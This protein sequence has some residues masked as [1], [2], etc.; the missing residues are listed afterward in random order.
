M[1][2]PAFNEWCQN[3]AMPRQS[4]LPPSLSAQLSALIT[5]RFR[6]LSDSELQDILAEFSEL[7]AK[8]IVDASREMTDVV[9]PYEPSLLEQLR[10][11][12]QQLMKRS[13]DY[14]W[15]FLFHRSGYVREAAL[16]VINAPPASAF[17]LSALAW[18]LNDWVG[19]VRQAAVRCAERVFPRISP[20]VAASAAPYLLDRR[21]VWAR[22]R[23]EAK[24]L[25]SVFGHTD[26]M[27]ALAMRMQKQQTG[28][29]ASCL[30][31]ALRYPEIDKHLPRLAIDAIQPSVRVA[32]YQCLLSGRATWPVG[33]GWSWIDKVY[34]LRKRVR[35]LDSREIQRASPAA[36]WIRRGIH[37]RSVLVR[38]VAADAMVGARA[39]LPDADSLIAVLGSDRSSAV[40]SRAD[41]ML[42]HPQ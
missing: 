34:G 30:R 24:V 19:A 18:R 41:Y 21:F 26:V 32:A 40:R 27:A 5:R 1:H 6:S 3:A 12:E 7:P 37:D 22:W 39:Q 2:L 11:S 8:L 23:E 10:K 28:T 4:V 14:A 36:D 42:R 15:L 25:D 38:R 17:F 9:S 16:D 31:H 29:Y 13:H 20:E 33:Y 35:M